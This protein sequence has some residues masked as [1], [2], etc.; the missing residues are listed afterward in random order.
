MGHFCSHTNYFGSPQDKWV[1]QIESR[2]PELDIII[3]WEGSFQ[4]LSLVLLDLH[5]EQV[6]SL[7]FGSKL[8]LESGLLNDKTI[9]KARVH[10]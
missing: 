6:A 8:C 9:K 10:L 5:L 2:R 7:R 1:F 3:L 4:N